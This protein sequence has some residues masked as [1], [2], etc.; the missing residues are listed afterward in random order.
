MERKLLKHFETG[1]VPSGQDN[2]SKSMLTD[3]DDEDE[4][5]ALYERL[6]FQVA[7]TAVPSI[8]CSSTQTAH[9]PSF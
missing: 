2:K 9:Q 5:D 6:L 7:K 3:F 4:E 8:H 1:V